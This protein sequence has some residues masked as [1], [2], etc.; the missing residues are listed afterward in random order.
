MAREIDKNKFDLDFSNVP[1]DC[2]V[3]KIDTPNFQKG[4]KKLNVNIMNELLKG[5]AI[6]WSTAKKLTDLTKVEKEFIWNHIEIS[7]Y[8]N[9][10]RDMAEKPFDINDVT[11]P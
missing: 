4:A 9:A 5:N 8:E 11:S 6:F 10:E 1:I 2:K 3:I 7:R